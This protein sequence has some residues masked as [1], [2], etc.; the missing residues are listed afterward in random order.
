M[1]RMPAQARNLRLTTNY[2]P[3]LKFLVL[4]LVEM[5]RK[6]CVGLTFHIQLALS[7]L[8]NAPSIFT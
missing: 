8:L 2:V 4:K 7:P 3:T 6:V 1:M 5:L